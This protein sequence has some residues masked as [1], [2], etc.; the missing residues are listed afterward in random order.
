M[1]EILGQLVKAEILADARHARGLGQGFKGAEQY[2]ARV[3][4]VIGAFVR[5][6]QHGQTRQP[7][8]RFGHDV[9]MLTGMQRQRDA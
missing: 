6:A 9:E 1:R 4:L 8:N 2:L 7:D 3:F 5:H